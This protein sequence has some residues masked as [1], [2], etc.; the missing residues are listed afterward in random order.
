MCVYGALRS[1][2]RAGAAMDDYDLITRHSGPIA[3][4]SPRRDRRM[5]AVEAVDVRICSRR[6]LGRWSWT[7]TP[8]GGSRERTRD[9][10]RRASPDERVA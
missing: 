10:L 2:T 3:T 7:A 6:A 8:V 1:A 9:S 4:S 5:H